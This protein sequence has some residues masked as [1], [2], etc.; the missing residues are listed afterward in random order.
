MYQVAMKEKEA[1]SN[2]VCSKQAWKSHCLGWHHN[3]DRI[4]WF[5]LFKWCWISRIWWRYILR[6]TARS[7]ACKEETVSCGSKRSAGLYQRRDENVNSPTIYHFIHGWTI[8]IVPILPTK[9]FIISIW[10]SFKFNECGVLAYFTSD[11]TIHWPW[12]LYPQ[13]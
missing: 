1:P 8:N 10:F 12:P 7:G 5:W 3:R 6:S 2:K 9:T 4:F 13:K 11:S